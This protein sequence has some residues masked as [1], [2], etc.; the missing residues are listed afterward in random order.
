[1]DARTRAGGVLV[2]SEPVMRPSQADAIRAVYGFRPGTRLDGSIARIESPSATV[3]IPR[4]EKWREWSRKARNWAEVQ[5]WQHPLATSI[6]LCLNELVTNSFTHVHTG[7]IGISVF[8]T[9]HKIRFEVVN[10]RSDSVPHLCGGIGEADE[11]DEHGRG[12][13]TVAGLTDGHWGTY[14]DTDNRQVTYFEILGPA[15][16]AERPA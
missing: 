8:A 3:T 13:I 15:R 12:L 16:H 1:V 14:R 7:D 4:H 10:D 2:V 9:T 11:H 5:F 6:T